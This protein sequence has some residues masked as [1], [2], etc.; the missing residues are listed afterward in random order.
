MSVD[1][2]DEE[3]LS[4]E[5]QQELMEEVQ[6]RRSHRG[7][8]VVIVSLIAIT[9]SAFQ[10]W[11]A[12]RGYVFGGTLPVVGE[13]RLVGFQQLQVNA[14]HVAFGLVLAFLLFPTSRGN[15][16]LARRLGRIEPAVRTRFGDEH[17]LTRGTAKAAGATRWAFLDTDMDRVAPADVI[18]AGIAM[19]PAY[20]IAT[21]YDEIQQI[22]VHRFE[23]TQSLGEVFPFLAPVEA[24][25]TAVGIPMADASAAF[26]LAV[27]G[28]LLVLEATRRA[29]GLL[30]TSLVALF[31]IYARWGY[32]IP[33]DS[34]IGA[35]SIQ[36][37]TWANIMYNLWYTVEAGVHSQ[38]VSV[39]VRFIYIFILFGAFLEM[40][41]AGRWF[42][43]MA[44]SA[45]GTREG[46]PAKAS[47]VSSGFMGMLSGSSI[48]NTVTTG[49]F[50]IPLMKRS[51]YSPEFSGAVESSSSSGGQMLPPVMG[52]AAFLIVEFTGTPYADVI[53]AATLPALAFFFGMW[54]MVHFEAIRGGIGGLPRSELPDV[55][56]ALR[57]GWFYLIPLI[58][59]LYYLVIARYSINRAGWLTIV[60]VVAL[61]AIVAAY[62]ERTRIPLLSTLLAAY[63]A[64][65]AA[66]A[67]VGSGLLDAAQA[68][69]GLETTGEPLAVGDAAMAAIGDLG[70]IA[71][72][73]SAVFILLRPRA[74]APLLDFD[75]A[76]DEAANRSA[77]AFNRPS[78]SG[79]RA[80]RFGTFVLKSMD[81]G[82]RTATT[83]VV[84]V[85]A[86]GVVPGVI[87]VSGLGP[88]LAALISEIS[89]DSMLI[90]LSLTGVAAII[91]G[92]GM[93]TTAMY[94]ILVAMLEAPLVEAGVIVL[95][96]H[97]FVLYWGL[98]A[99]V[100]PPVA[101]AAFAGAGVA[102]A[103]EM[104]TATIAFLLS[105]NKVLV[106][107]AFVFS[108]GILLLRDGEVM[109]WGDVTDIGFVVPEVVIPVLGMFI[110]VYAL[111]VTIIG[112][113]YTEVTS[114]NRAL[115][116]IS[117]ILL[118]VPEIPLL[119]TEAVLTL[120][121][122]PSAL[123]IFEIT[124]SLRGVGL[125]MLVVLTYRNRS[126]ADLEEAD[127]DAAASAPAAGDA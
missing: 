114:V 70:V 42:I 89:G 18:L 22:A 59:L 99:D 112:Y 101:V 15:G 62:D 25:L 60:A 56:S 122:V 76:V 115:Y 82:A 91:F 79:N 126:R 20:Y 108:P 38:P 24:G 94:I 125:A 74:D 17:P 34:A 51:G 65:A 57:S 58:L 10:M 86:A 32:H 8:A 36:P 6:R 5:E 105:L 12:A 29:L 123:T 117:S 67:T 9:F 64:Q 100:T 27:V 96:A 98:M 90:L 61:L 75:P 49:A 19:M 54:V 116:S 71:I 13:Y 106:P 102:K 28:M 73:V 53:I 81:S 68:A 35:L 104:K 66:Y 121:G 21:N 87:S 127:T 23:E 7:L 48:A 111:G 120:A 26:V 110:G 97:L 39:S 63:V 46:G 45:T 30:L 84:A 118:M 41:G 83:V 50:T 69:A 77:K 4:D 113:Q 3:A 37:D 92:M 52:A 55:R 44:Y 95:A 31:I 33:S 88:N 78:L 85:A 16:F 93:P 124:A 40:S 14:I 47:V 80:Y 119:L 1:R 72:L 2:G 11:I 107:F 109:G 103:E 43:D